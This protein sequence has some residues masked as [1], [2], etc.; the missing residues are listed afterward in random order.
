MTVLV[1]YSTLLS[2]LSMRYYKL[3]ATKNS[4]HLL[5]TKATNV[6]VFT[7]EVGCTGRYESYASVAKGGTN[8]TSKIQHPTKNETSV[9]DQF[10][11]IPASKTGRGAPEPIRIAQTRSLVMPLRPRVREKRGESRNCRHYRPVIH[12]H[13]NSPIGLK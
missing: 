12:N 5:I 8:V 1:L 6:Y 7:M 9:Y 4:I 10:V 13:K 3:I 2:P 11:A